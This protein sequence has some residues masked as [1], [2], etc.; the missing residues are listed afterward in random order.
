MVFD[1]GEDG[2]SDVSDESYAMRKEIDEDEE[3]SVDDSCFVNE[4]EEIDDRQR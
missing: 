3:V 1:V 2:G 4:V